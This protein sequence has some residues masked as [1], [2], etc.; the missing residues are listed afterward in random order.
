MPRDF[1]DFETELRLGIKIHDNGIYW[2]SPS[3]ISNRVL[4]IELQMHVLTPFKHANLQS[5]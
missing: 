1:P 5:E 3:Y 4:R 2:K